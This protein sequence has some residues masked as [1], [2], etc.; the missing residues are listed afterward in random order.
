MPDEAAMPCG[1]A[2][3]RIVHPCIPKVSVMEVPV[4]LLPEG[5]LIVRERP[6]AEN[7]QFVVGVP[8]VCTIRV[9]SQPPPNANCGKIYWC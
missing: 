7:V 6:C 8:L 4:R 2:V 5:F 9:D 3:F 1:V